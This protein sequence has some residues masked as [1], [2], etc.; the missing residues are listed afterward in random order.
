MLAF[1]QTIIAKNRSF[2]YSPNKA[3]FAAISYINTSLTLFIYIYAKKNCAEQSK[4]IDD[5]N[6]RKVSCELFNRKLFVIPARFEL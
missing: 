4:S 6:K 3:G 2:P 1:K 5:D